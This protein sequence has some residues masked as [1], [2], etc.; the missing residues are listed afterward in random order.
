MDSTA[1]IAH[2]IQAA[3]RDLGLPKPSDE[4]ARYVIGLGLR[5]ALRLS[6]RDSTLLWAHDLPAPRGAAIM[7]RTDERVGALARFIL[8]GALDKRLD[9]QLRPARRAG[10]MTT[11]AVDALTVLLLARFRVHVT[12]PGRHGIRTEVAEEA[13]T[14]A[15]RG[16]PAKPTWL[17]SDELNALLA[18]QPCAN[19]PPDRSRS[20]VDG[21]L[22]A[23]PQLIPALDAEARR[24]ADELREAHTRV[25]QAARGRETAG[26]LGIRGLHVSPQLPVDLLGAYVYV[27][28]GAA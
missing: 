2:S 10:V 7:A 23:L 21:V 4:S 15:F 17:E 5:D 25:R 27:P 19:T 3:C 16:S 6:G 24:A 14:L 11:G 26:V 18:A 22:R 12:L 1:H 8:D 20:L 9:E 28:S 13:R